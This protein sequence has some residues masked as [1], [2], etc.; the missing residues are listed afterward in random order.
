MNESLITFTAISGSLL[1]AFAYL[2]YIRFTLKDEVHPNPTSWLMWTYGTAL[3]VVLEW[4]QDAGLSVLLLP[5]VCATCSIFVALNCWHKGQLCW[6]DALSDRA[7]FTLDLVLTAAYVVLIALGAMG[8]MSGSDGTALKSL[9][10]VIVNISTVLSFWP[11]L[12]STRSDPANEHWLVWAIWT[13]TYSNML[14]VTIATHGI[15]L[16]A[17]QFWLYPLI[18]LVLTGAVGFYALRP[19]KAIRFGMNTIHEQTL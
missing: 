14:F 10:L 4:D 19:F 16:Y 18:C 7:A 1:H 11:I 2:L 9:L 13:I 12:R 17:L 8:Y 15:S 5:I 6:P 3:V